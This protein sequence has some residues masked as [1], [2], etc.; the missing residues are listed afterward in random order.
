M[1]INDFENK[2][3][4]PKYIR[5]KKKDNL[6]Y[7][8]IYDRKVE[9]E[10]QTMSITFIDNVQYYLSILKSRIQEKYNFII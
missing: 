10:R 9:N 4:L 7:C 3:K 5:L 1:E 8:L 6:K 2:N